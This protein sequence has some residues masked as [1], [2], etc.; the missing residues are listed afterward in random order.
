MHRTYSMRSSRAPTASELQNPPP[1]TSSTK[2]G[3][4]FG[5]NPLGENVPL[6]FSVSQI[7]KGQD[8]LVSEQPRE[9]LPTCVTE[10][11]EVSIVRVHETEAYADLATNFAV[12]N[13]AGWLANQNADRPSS[14]SSFTRGKPLRRT[15]SGRPR[16]S[17][18]R[19]CCYTP[20][21]TW[22]YRYCSFSNSVANLTCHRACYPYQDCR[23]IRSRSRQEAYNPCQDGKEL[24]EK[25]G[26][27]WS[28]ENGSRCKIH[29]CVMCNN[30]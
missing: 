17:V 23:R 9:L 30:Y 29:I 3:R 24:D 7:S 13:V 21:D 1:P 28:R 4:L 14:P 12:E 18:K 15:M 8:T 26:A 27:C 6:S 25:Y 19:T 2:S 20:K 5:K 22:S 11:D 16:K 10:R